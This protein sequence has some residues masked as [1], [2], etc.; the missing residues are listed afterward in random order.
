MAQDLSPWH[1]FSAS[2]QEESAF[3]LLSAHLAAQGQQVVLRGKPD[4]EQERYQ[5]RFGVAAGALTVDAHLAIDGADWYV[6]HTTVPL[7]GSAWMPSAIRAA[8]D[9]LN[10]LL[11]RA[12]LLS[13]TGGLRIT[14]T[15]QQGTAKERNRYF[16]R[17]AALGEQAARTGRPVFDTEAADFNPS[18]SFPVAEPWHPADPSQPVILSFAL[19]QPL[20]V[21]HR[22]TPHG[23]I[24]D[25]GPAGDVLAHPIHE[26]L[27]AN[28]QKNGGPGQL[29]RAARI[30]LTTGLLIDARVG[31]QPPHLYADHISPRKPP[32]AIAPL[33]HEVARTLMREAASRHPDVLNRAWLITADDSVHEVYVR[34]KT[35]SSDA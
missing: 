18:Y 11:A 5:Q 9:A 12:L 10:R 26:K 1:L 14:V 3:R 29:R 32:P 4:D 6:D 7:P 33:D 23:W 8:S 15:P 30:G 2:P 13:P 17:L 16:T 35:P 19:P 21:H 22:L 27:T 31:W 34:P 25:L 24:H 20:Q 28:K